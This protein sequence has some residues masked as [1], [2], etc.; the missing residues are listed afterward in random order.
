MA[1]PRTW[2]ASRD[3]VM[4]GYPC[5]AL[6]P[7]SDEAWFRAVTVRAPAPAVFRWLCQ[8]R[9]APYSYDWID[10][11]GRQSPRQLTDGLERLEVGQTVM[12]I[13][14][15]R[16]F[17]PGRSLTVVNRSSRGGHRRYGEFWVSYLVVPG[18]AGA[19]RLVAK[20]LV[21]YPPGLVGWL[22][23]G[24][25]PLGDLVMMR[26]QLLT[27]KALSERDAAARG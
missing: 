8:L 25:L 4:A 7:R 14:E 9:A 11:R 12:T 20:L 24:L 23:R 5:D 6:C 15:L 3:E 1:F 16:A 18:V 2:G 10:N 17:E 13:F 27:L 26:R 21:T 22:M 19:C